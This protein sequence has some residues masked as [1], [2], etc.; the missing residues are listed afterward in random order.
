[1]P[2]ILLVSEDAALRQLAEV[3]LTRGGHEL[4]SVGRAEQG[5][6]ATFSI[7][8]DALLFDCATLRHREE[9]AGLLD[10][11][12]ERNDRMAAI[13]ITAVPESLD[14]PERIATRVLKKPLAA[15][16][17]E[18]AIVEALEVKRG[19]AGAIPIDGVGLELDTRRH[20]LR[21]GARAVG[22]SAKEFELARYFAERPTQVISFR[23]VL[24]DVWCLPLEERSLSTLRSHVYNLRRKIRETGVDAEML[25]TMKGRGYRLL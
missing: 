22:L 12:L 20:E 5:V 3:I 24:E 19:D 10:W 11:L 8:V 18:T 13:M 15:R 21:C 17:L 16:D 4:I 6:R 2:S 14:L 23:D 9:L 1:M 7:K 25:R